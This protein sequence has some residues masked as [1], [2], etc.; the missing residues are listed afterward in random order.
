MTRA[1]IEQM[2]KPERLAALL[3]ACNTSKCI[4]IGTIKSLPD[5]PTWL[6]NPTT[7]DGI[8]IVFYT[9]DTKNS[10]VYMPTRLFVSGRHEA[11]NGC[12]V[13]TIIEIASDSEIQK[14]GIPVVLRARDPVELSEIDPNLVTTRDDGAILLPET[15]VKYYV[16]RETT[17]I[18]EEIARAQAEAAEETH[19]LQE[20]Q[21]RRDAL[22]AESADVE[23]QI[24]QRVRDR[25]TLESEVSGLQDAKAE[26]ARRV[27]E[28]Q[29]TARVRLDRLVELG[30]LS[31]EQA[32]LL[33]PNEARDG[34]AGERSALGGCPD[35]DGDLGALPGLIQ[36]YLHHSRRIHYPR[37]LL[38]DF[39]TLMRT[40]DIVL[41]AG[42]P[43]S[44]KTELARSFADAI[45]GVS[46]IIPVK[47]NW[48]S[49]DDLM[50][51]FNPMHGSYVTTPFL[52]AL[53][54]ARSDQ[55]RLHLICLDE[56]NLARIEYYFADFLSAF[57]ERHQLARVPL[58]AS[59]EERRARQ[60]FGE[61]A[62][63]LCADLCTEQATQSWDGVEQCTA[64]RDALWATVGLRSDAGGY[65][66]RRR[67]RCLAASIVVP[68]TLEIPPNVRII[69]TLNVDE[70]GHYLSPK[71][72]DRVHVLRVPSPLDHL[73]QIR[74]EVSEATTAAGHDGPVMVSPS[75]LRCE[76]RPYPDVDLSHGVGR[77]LDEW[78]R[79][80]LAPLGLEL[81]IRVIRQAQLYALL[82][83]EVTA[84]EDASS[85]EAVAV[86]NLLL[87]KV[88]PRFMTVS[89]TSAAHDRP[90]SAKPKRDIAEELATAVT[91]SVG[92]AVL[93]RYRAMPASST[94][95]LR[96]MV[97]ASDTDG[98]LNYWG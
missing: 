49:P 74:Q 96:R 18:R 91:N 94:E 86:N 67:L 66:A 98:I 68:S 93:Q 7:A 11:L 78:N 10:I 52:D 23:E 17:T 54:N 89:A 61:V 16:S 8:P 48:T 30:L 38:D 97:T 15:T 21:V 32:A 46:H 43:G 29:A 72:L 2:T 87:H 1:E 90:Q 40:H 81:G 26:L 14:Q 62:R 33:L 70:T 31:S 36:A 55:G 65:D 84:D 19:K 47:P 85:V 22:V 76:R 63:L 9:T 58:Y 95:E 25:A 45:G 27:D 53:L 28:E 83:A 59:D 80:Y 35:F 6:H 82:F 13:Q 56:M 34:A 4:A 64:V 57:E 3:A 39:L 71:V 92:R 12:T 75:A 24:A 41:L 20:A 5:Q 77:R 79:N 73:D 42:Q 37:S 51:F 60:E 69:G 88:L 50:G 44:G